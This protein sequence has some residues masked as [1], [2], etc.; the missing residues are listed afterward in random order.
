MKKLTDFLLMALL[1]SLLAPITLAY[2]LDDVIT[3]KETK[4]CV[5][6]DLRRANLEGAILYR[7]KLEGANLEGAN[8]ERA[9]LEGANLEGAHLEGAKLYRA[10]LEG[11]N[12]ERANL[13]GANLE[14]AHLEGAKLYRANLE[15]ANLYRANLEEALLYKANLE[16]A[17]FQ[18]ANLR[19]AI[20]WEANFINANLQ[21]AKLYWTDFDGAKL[22]DTIVSKGDFLINLEKYRIWQRDFHSY[23]Y[24]FWWRDEIRYRYRYRYRKRYSSPG[25]LKIKFPVKT[26]TIKKNG[27]EYWNQFYGSSTKNYEITVDNVDSQADIIIKLYDS[28]YR[29]VKTV[30]KHSKGKKESLTWTTPQGK[31]KE[32]YY[33]NIQGKNLT[34]NSYQLK[35]Y[36][37]FSKE[38]DI[39]IPSSRNRSTNGPKNE[40]EIDEPVTLNGGG[41]TDPV[42]PPDFSLEEL[43]NRANE[44][45]ELGKYRPALELYKWALPHVQKTEDLKQEG[46]TI[47]LIGE[48]HH[49][50]GE[51]KEALEN[52]RQSLTIYKDKMNDKSLAG[53]TLINIG[54]VYSH[55]NQHEK[56]LIYYQR[57]LELYQQAND[58]NGEG[59]AIGNIANTYYNLGQYKKA[60]S[61]YEKALK[62]FQQVEDRQNEAT[63]FANQ[64]NTYLSQGQ[65]KLALEKYQ[66]AQTIFQEIGNAHGEAL[67]FCGMGHVHTTLTQYQQALSRFQSCLT[68]LEGYKALDNLWLVH[69]QLGFVY[70]RL[71]KPQKAGKHYR[72]AIKSIEALRTTL[73]SEASKLLF[74]QDKYYVYDEFIQLL[75]LL[76]KDYPDQGY[77][78]DSLAIFE[79][80]QGRKMIEE[81]GKS[82]ARRF[83]RLPVNVADKE[84]ELE[85]QLAKIRADLIN[86]MP[87][88]KDEVELPEEINTLK[89]RLDKIKQEQ[90]EFH[91]TLKEEHFGYYTMKYPKP[92]VLAELQNRILKKDEILLIYGV[93]EKNTV[94]WIVGK[95][96]FDLMTLSES[97]E[98]M[99]QKDVT[100]FLENIQTMQKAVKTASQLSYNRQQL[101]DWL[102]QKND[103]TL[104]NL[105]NIS[106]RLYQKLLPA[107]AREPLKQ[108]K[109]IYVVPT[110]PLYGLPFEALVTHI[111]EETETPYYLIQDIA[112]A[113]LS[114]ASLLKT[115]RNTKIR[116]KAKAP[117][118]LLAFAHPNYPAC[119]ERKIQERSPDDFIGLRTFTYRQM[120]DDQCFRRLPETEEEVT[121]IAKSLKVPVDQ[122]LK[123]HEE[124]SRETVLKLNKENRLDDYRFLVFAGHAVLQAETN[125]IAQPALVLSHEKLDENAYLTTKDVLGFQLNADFVTLSACYTGQGEH[126]KGEGIRGLTRAFM[127]AGTPAVSV[128]LW[129]V[130]S[131]SAKSLSTGL[132]KYLSHSERKTPLAKALQQAKLELITGKGKVYE[133][134]PYFWAPFVIWGDG[135]SKPYKESE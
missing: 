51:S 47:S 72:Q 26:T 33:V 62:I 124:A 6:C 123:L 103:D 120:V 116:N 90:Q 64:G 94:L 110:G 44:L 48:M 37:H 61:H 128:T 8:L 75:L 55:L 18:N 10:N 45:K 25:I 35:V 56:A 5:G 127:Y 89:E 41:S 36:E 121:E 104:P 113:Y 4:R 73:T 84:R 129:A 49:K 108:A 7:A 93:M 91:E 117:K 76:H 52:Y 79:Q 28:R 81:L 132:F 68:I 126:I 105:F 54:A 115:L 98:S 106:H 30:D 88:F 58:Q 67:A 102:Q 83:A 22:I 97:G 1:T 125:G 57:S 53:Q 60:L 77:D 39:S 21:E 66:Q 12:L 82:N 31:G 107:K 50:L 78:Y 15:G 101:R 69:A 85:D 86:K 24:P 134:H 13:E 3:L 96:Y 133:S 20:F 32:D 9:N 111:D 74:I 92:A 99:L 16:G 114:S 43:L 34:E 131:Q 130:E 112:I 27:S 42:K 14:G 63:V 40:A 118:P 109:R 135:F 87:D 80:K 11:A 65:S 19:K 23:L 29:L 2:D 17:N 38:D 122:A 59:L 119:P 71:N 70:V 95:G 46:D 100:A